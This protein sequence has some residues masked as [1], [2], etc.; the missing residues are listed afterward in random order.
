MSLT[1]RTIPKFDKPIE[2]F[3]N[4]LADM[5]RDSNLVV[6]LSEKFEAKI[7]NL[8]LDHAQFSEA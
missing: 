7:D 4:D 1:Q 2:A 5:K 6:D 8:I 3:N